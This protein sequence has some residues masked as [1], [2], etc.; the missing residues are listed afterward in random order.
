MTDCKDNCWCK[1]IN[2]KEKSCNQYFMEHFHEKLKKLE[3]SMNALAEMY[4]EISIKVVGLMD[5]QIRNKPH[6]CPVC[7]GLGNPDIT[8]LTAYG[9]R[10]HLIEND[11]CNSCNGTGIV[12]EK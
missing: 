5:S 4:K 7:K 12:W 8:E 11:P 9:P 10:R 3:S 6:K 2:K 1:T